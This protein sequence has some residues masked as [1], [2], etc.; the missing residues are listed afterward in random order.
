MHSAPRVRLYQL[1]EKA[2]NC[3][4]TIPDFSSCFSGFRPLSATAES[5][6]GSPK[7][8]RVALI[9]MQFVFSSFF[10]EIPFALHHCLRFTLKL[11]TLRDTT[12]CEC[13]DNRVCLVW[14]KK[15]SSRTQ[16][17]F[18]FI[19]FSQPRTRPPTG[20]CVWVRWK[21]RIWISDMTAKVHIVLV[22]LHQKYILTVSVEIP[23]NMNFLSFFER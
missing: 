10:M 11:N 17:D 20:K 14:P 15:A 23:R 9:S 21:F 7:T 1:S 16:C 2:R 12:F 6:M 13:T 22:H 4:F 18:I 3:I 8:E 19:Y 5:A